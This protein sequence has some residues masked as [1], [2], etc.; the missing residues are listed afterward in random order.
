MK[1]FAKAIERSTDPTDT[2]RKKLLDCDP[3]D[4]C[5]SARNAVQDILDGMTKTSGKKIDI[6]PGVLVR[7]YFDPNVPGG[8]PDEKSTSKTTLLAPRPE[9]GC[10]SIFSL[11]ANRTD[12]VPH[13]HWDDPV[14]AFGA[15]L[16]CCYPPWTPAVT[17]RW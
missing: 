9:N 10:H 4:T 11:P 6:P 16:R 12:A 15:H 5:A 8:F 7:F 3:V 2:I 1:A 13:G 14:I 17:C